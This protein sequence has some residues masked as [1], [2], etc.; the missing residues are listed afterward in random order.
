MK[1]QENRIS[2]LVRQHQIQI[3]AKSEEISTAVEQFKLALIEAEYEMK[4]FYEKKK[5][6]EQ[7]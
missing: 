7:V 5:F 3:K 6:V 4:A 1:A 2:A